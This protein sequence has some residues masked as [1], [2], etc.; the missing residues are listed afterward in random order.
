MEQQGSVPSS[1][2]RPQ[3]PSQPRLFVASQPNEKG[4]R[5]QPRK[6][7]PRTQ[8]GQ[9]QAPRTQTGQRQAGQS[10]RQ[11]GLQAIAL[12]RSAL[13]EATKR[14]QARSAPKAA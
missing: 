9:R 10:S 4:T 6:Q 11:L 3:A 2:N 7:A 13:A 1:A 14:A 12:A 8:T 5:C